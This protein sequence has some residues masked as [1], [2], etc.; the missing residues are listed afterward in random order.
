MNAFHQRLPQEYR[1]EHL[2]DL[3]YVD[4]TKTP[5]EKWFEPD[6]KV[7]PAPLAQEKIDEVK[8]STEEKKKPLRKLMREREK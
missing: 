8:H 1:K 6:D 3:E 7:L 2:K 4:G 5:K